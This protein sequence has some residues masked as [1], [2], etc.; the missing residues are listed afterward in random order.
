MNKVRSRFV[1]EEEAAEAEE[2]ALLR[3]IRDELKAQRGA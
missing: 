3:E 2:I 1:Q